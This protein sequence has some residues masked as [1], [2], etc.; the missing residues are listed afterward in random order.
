MNGYGECIV[1]VDESGDH[2]LVNIDPEYPVFVLLFCVM[3]MSHY[4]GTVAPALKML[5][6]RY[7]GHDGIIL[8][9]H[10]IRKKTGPFSRFGRET[11]EAFLTELTAIM[12]AADFRIVAVVIDKNEHRK[13]YVDPAHPYHL[14]MQFGLERLHYML[15]PDGP[16][17]PPITHI[18]C[19]A[20]GQKE[21]RQ[22]ELEFRRICDGGNGIGTRLPFEIVFLDKRALCEGLQLADLMARPVGLSVLRPE[23]PNRAMEALESKFYR[24]NRGEKDGYGLKVFP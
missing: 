1:F 19:E 9:E 21:D 20:R 6:F 11:R 4:A 18:I 3:R 14:A 10:D 23:Q 24:S 13:R 2:G 5:K 17:D 12:Q 16:G 15:A 22:L 8:H 7:F